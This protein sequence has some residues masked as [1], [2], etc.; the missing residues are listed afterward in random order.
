MRIATMILS[1]ILMLVVGAQSCAVTVGDA[2]GNE[3]SAT[4]GGVIGIFMAFLFLIGGAF[5]LAFPLVSFIAFVIAGLSGLGAGASTSFSDL[6]IWGIVSFVLAALSF[7]G[8]R[9]KRRQRE[10]SAARVR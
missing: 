5:A 7:F 3:P 4:Q 10:E 9:E 6:T 1:L 2:L 8:W